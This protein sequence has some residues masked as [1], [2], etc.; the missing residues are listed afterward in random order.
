MQH[1]LVVK[2]ICCYEKE[3]RKGKIVNINYI[4]HK[5]SY[6][7]ADIGCQRFII[8]HLKELVMNSSIKLWNNNI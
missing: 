7:L 5:E 4:V 6:M 1:G 8:I 2:H 3:N